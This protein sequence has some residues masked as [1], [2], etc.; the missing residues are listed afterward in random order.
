MTEYEDNVRP[1]KWSYPRRNRIV[2]ALSDA[3]VVVQAAEGSGSL[4]TAKLARKYD[5]PLG[6]VPGNAGDPKSRGCN[7]LLRQGVPLVE[8]VEDVLRLMSSGP[9][10]TQL[11]L[12][13]LAERPSAK[14][15][16]PTDLAGDEQRVFDLLE[17]GT[18]HIDD[19]IVA[20]GM[21]VAKLSAS[22]AAAND[23]F[24][25]SGCI[26]CGSEHSTAS[27]LKLPVG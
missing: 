15:Q 1:S 20:T 12:P 14:P 6:A 3:V 19:I 11:S 22:D 24:G 18:M 17:D 25:M 2:A 4:I 23:Q 21:E 8:N 16:L 7:E 9:A 13:T 27:S 5:I 26:G 10:P